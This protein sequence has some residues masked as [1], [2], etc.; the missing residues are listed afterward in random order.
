MDVY[1]CCSYDVIFMAGPEE[2]LK[3]FHKT[4]SKVLFSAEGFCWPD[5]SLAVSF[6]KEKLP[7]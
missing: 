1:F 6:L 5:A 2:I 4:K 3:K 7:L